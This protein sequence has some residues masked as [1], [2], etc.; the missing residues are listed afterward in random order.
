MLSGEHIRLRAVERADL[1]QLRAWRNAP[2][3]RR[4]FRGRRELSSDDQ[5]AW[6]E[7][8][9]RAGGQAPD[10]IMFSIQSA[11]TDELVGACGLCYIDWVDRTAEL[12]AYVGADLV[13]VDDVLAPDACRILIA[14]AFGELGLQR[15]WVEVYAYDV[16][17]TNLLQALGFA[18]EGRLRMHRFRMGARHDSLLFGLLAGQ[19]HAPTQ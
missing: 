15:L 18:Q 12:S 19:A 14:H 9:A 2:E 10:T 1:E 6:F 11:A 17:K 7:R 3:L 13:Y 5:L 16:L 4:F 8:V